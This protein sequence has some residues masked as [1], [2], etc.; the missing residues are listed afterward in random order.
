HN[1]NLIRGC[2]NKELNRLDKVGRKSLEGKVVLKWDIVN[3]GIAKDVRVVSSTLGSAEIEKCIAERLA[4]IIF[5][6]PPKGTTA[7][8][9][10]PFVFKNER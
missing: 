10:Y 1:L 6:D 3:N 2:Y 4:T 8:V 7:E 9:V 5:P